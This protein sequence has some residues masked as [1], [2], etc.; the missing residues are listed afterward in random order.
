M[1]NDLTFRLKSQLKKIT[2][3]DHVW[4]V[5][6]AWWS[7]WMWYDNS[8]WEPKPDFVDERDMMK[9]ISY[10]EQLIVYSDASIVTSDHFHFSS[11]ERLKYV[12]GNWLL[13]ISDDRCK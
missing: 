8:N 11:T 12:V 3:W 5:A 6:V 2:Y 13:D 9:T 4:L 1:I 10:V 7:K